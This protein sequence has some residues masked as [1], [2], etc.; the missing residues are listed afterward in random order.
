MKLIAVLV[1]AIVPIVGAKATINTRQPVAMVACKDFKA[2]KA[3]ADIISHQKPQAVPGCYAMP[4]RL[5]NMEWLANSAP[6][7][8]PEADWEGDIFA[9][10]HVGAPGRDGFYILVYFPSSW[11]SAPSA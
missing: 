1:L 3:F 11:S 10:Y 5:V 7:I 4:P 8:G 9:F 6:A 2:A